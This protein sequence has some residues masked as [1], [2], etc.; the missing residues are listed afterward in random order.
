MNKSA[1]LILLTVLLAIAWL[2]VDRC[3]A[4]IDNSSLEQ[5]QQK[6]SRLVKELRITEVLGP[7]APVALSPFFG[8]ACLSGISILCSNGLLPENEFLV[9]HEVLNN[10]YIFVSFLVLTVIT[11]IPNSN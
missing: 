8:L 4:G 10:G 1:C 9:G 5:D 2:G 7:L 11:S 3:S 6:A